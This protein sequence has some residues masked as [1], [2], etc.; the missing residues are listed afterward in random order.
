MRV[1]VYHPTGNQNVRAL[2]RGLQRHDMLQSFHTTVAV[3]ESSWYY[4]LLRGIMRKF[5]RRTYDN[6]LKTYTH[7]YPW[8]ELL[9]FA[10]V[11]QLHHHTLTPDYI[12]LLITRKVVNYIK[13]HHS[14]I[15]L[16]YCYPG[17]SSLVMETAHKYNIKCVYE[18]TTAYYKHIQAINA[19]EDKA[20]PSWAKLI[21]VA[22]GSKAWQDEMDKE[23]ALADIVVCASSYIKSTLLDYKCV[24]GR[25]IHIIPYGFPLTIEKE[26]EVDIPLKL[27]YVGNLSQLKGLSYM[28][29]AVNH[30][31]NKVQL[32]I[33][34]EGKLLASE[35]KDVLSRYNYL[36]AKSHDDVL[37]EMEK[38]DI[39]LFPTLTDGFGMVVTEAMAMGTPVIATTNSCGRDIIKNGANGWLISI[40]NAKAI[41]SVIEDIIENPSIMTRIIHEALR[42]AEERP[43]KK[44]EDEIAKFLNSL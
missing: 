4:G 44:Y 28:F 5:K 32:T 29:D 21:T 9:M 2:L 16:V 6:E 17:H 40:Q 13:R 18:L 35:L 38:A 43:W 8:H 27:L 12:D 23:L 25:K 14:E 1:L 19:S 24:D 39:L 10:G 3:F 37:R 11:K 42:T 22:R 36:G 30:F 31:G 20:N 26:R 33:I 15:D 7:T 34:G 41:Q